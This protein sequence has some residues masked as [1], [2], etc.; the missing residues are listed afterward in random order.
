VFADKNASRRWQSVLSSDSKYLV[1]HPLG[2]KVGVWWHAG[3]AVLVI[4]IPKRSACL[5]GH[6]EVGAH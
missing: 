6:D 3:E 2:G 4:G 5:H 1:M